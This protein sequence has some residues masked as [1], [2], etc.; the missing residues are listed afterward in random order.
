MIGRPDKMVLVA[1]AFH[2]VATSVEAEERFEIMASSWQ[3]NHRSLIIREI[4]RTARNYC[5]LYVA[6]AAKLL[7][8]TVSR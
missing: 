6:N 5:I 7:G 1:M 8:V 3:G 4:F 2:T